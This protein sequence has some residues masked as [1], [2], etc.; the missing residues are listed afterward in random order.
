MRM[1]RHLLRL[2]YSPVIKLGC[3]KKRSRFTGVNKGVC[4]SVQL[5]HMTLNSLFHTEV[6]ALLGS[7]DGDVPPKAF[8]GR[9]LN[10]G[11]SEAHFGLSENVCILNVRAEATRPLEIVLVAMTVQF[12]RANRN[13]VDLRPLDKVSK[14]YF[15]Q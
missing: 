10:N 5:R 3:P 1:V 8:G 4:F 11:L 15:N 9:R 12:I 14:V 13:S 6:A 2:V 7:T